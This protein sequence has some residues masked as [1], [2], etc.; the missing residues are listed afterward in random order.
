QVNGRTKTV[1]FRLTYTGENR[2]SVADVTNALATF[3][4]AQND[5][6]RS[7][8]ATRTAEFLKGQMADAKRQVDHHEQNLR[9]FAAQHSGELTNLEKEQAAREEKE[10]AAQGSTEKAP[11]P[12]KDLP[13]ARK[14]ALEKMDDELARLKKTEADVRGQIAAFEKRLEGVPELQ[15][16]YALL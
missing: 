8:E 14:R 7:E 1:A 12:A 3:Y 15:Q 16:E 13:P 6:M 10:A 5:R 9:T 11:E 2:D 4:V